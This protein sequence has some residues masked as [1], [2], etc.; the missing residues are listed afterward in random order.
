[1]RDRAASREP[2]ESPA[3]RPMDPSHPR[4]GV[5]RPLP[6][7]P[8][9][10]VRDRERYGAG[11]VRFGVSQVKCP[12]HPRD[13]E[14]GLALLPVPVAVLP[15]DDGLGA[16]PVV[17][18]GD[19]RLPDLPLEPGVLGGVHPE[20]LV[21][22]VLVAA[23]LRDRD[24]LGVGVHAP[25]A[26]PHGE[27][28]GVRPRQ[29]IRVIRVLLRGVVCRSRSRIAEVPFVGE[30][31]A[32]G[33][34][35]GVLEECGE[36]QRVVIEVRVATPR[37]DGLGKGL[38]AARSVVESER[39]HEGAG[40]GIGVHG[41]RRSGARSV[42]EVPLI[43]ELA[44]VTRRRRG[45][46]A[47]VDGRVRGMELE[48]GSAGGGLRV[49]LLSGAEHLHGEPL[50]DPR[51]EGIHGGPVDGDGDRRPQVVEQPGQSAG[52]RRSV[53]SSANF[54]IDAPTRTS[55]EGLSTVLRKS[56][57][58]KNRSGL[59]SDGSPPPRRNSSSSR[60]ISRRAEKKP[61]PSSN[62]PRRGSGITKTLSSTASSL[63]TSRGGR[64][65]RSIR[66]RMAS[67]KGALWTKTSATTGRRWVASPAAP[68]L[69][70]CSK[71]FP[72]DETRS[73]SAP[74]TRCDSGLAS[75]STWDI[76]RG[77]GA[78]AM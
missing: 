56:L 51:I 75:R 4:R 31:P 43:G 54:R 36:A 58:M 19:V 18:E 33:S 2:P 76:S 40:R 14:V 30:G 5:R 8:R 63:A 28:H 38:G 73:R 3:R 21:P 59:P 26:V 15:V 7:L 44:G 62:P 22:V 34:G 41:V 42:A 20:L 11:L 60:S 53:E 48:A 46:V 10:E 29:G 24:G 74:R 78:D 77:G 72:P 1:M 68:S 9:L 6:V 57:A 25:R 70:P 23:G 52:K 39:H 27:L 45:L 37:E 66:R 69:T 35:R 71:R 47:E 12:H 50:D 16:G 32:G 55:S 49:E 13:D 65:D 64:S 67:A 61:I 17:E